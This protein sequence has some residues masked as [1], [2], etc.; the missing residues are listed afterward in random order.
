MGKPIQEFIEHTLLRANATESEIV[1][2]TKE[3]RDLGVLGVCVNPFW[4]GLV[5]QQLSGTKLLPIS[6]VGFPLGA[7]DTKSLCCEIQHA[8]NAGAKEL[9]MVLPIG[10]A[11]GEQW[12][13]VR[14][15]LKAAHESCA[16]RPLK[17]I[18]ETALLTQAQIQKSTEVAVSLNIEFVKTS[19]GFS[20]RGASVEDVRCMFE[21]TKNSK[22]QIKASGGI[23]TA[24]FARELLNAGATRLGC[25]SSRQLIEEWKSEVAK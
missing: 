24:A 20:T 4:I 6:V 9:D 5:A 23:K 10:L 8:V 22:T 3:A 1:K 11:L 14:N 15:H 16:G 18:L 25:S 21:V 2:L 12:A 19:T 7:S 13:Q 17:V